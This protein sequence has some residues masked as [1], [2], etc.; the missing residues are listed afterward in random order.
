MECPLCGRKDLEILRFGNSN[1][2][3]LT[4]LVNI[5]RSLLA[6]EAYEEEAKK[7]K[8]RARRCAGRARRSRREERKREKPC[9]VAN[10]S[11]KNALIGLVGTSGTKGAF[12]V[13]DGDAGGRSI[14]SGGAGTI[15][16]NLYGVANCEADIVHPQGSAKRSDKSKN[17]RKEI[18][19][20]TRERSPRAHG[21]HHW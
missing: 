1:P 10:R 12:N 11:E 7:P 14:E 20:R 2:P 6:G 13:L 15:K 3:A 19:E 18:G 16:A 5:F 21:K 4:S 9:E 17:C 8:H